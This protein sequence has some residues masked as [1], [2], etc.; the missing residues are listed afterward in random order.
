MTWPSARRARCGGSRNPEPSNSPISSTPSASRSGAA[1]GSAVRTGTA[2]MVAVDVIAAA[3]PDPSAE[4]VVLVDVV[5][6][7]VGLGVG[8][9]AEHDILREH[10]LDPRLLRLDRGVERDGIEVLG[11]ERVEL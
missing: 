9:R 4:V 5:L 6:D 11:R 2:A 8:V 10:L 1:A 7:H 3:R